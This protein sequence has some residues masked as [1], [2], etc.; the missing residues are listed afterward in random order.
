MKCHENIYE[1]YQKYPGKS[2]GTHKTCQEYPVIL[3]TTRQN[4]KDSSN[5]WTLD[6]IPSSRNNLK[7][8]RRSPPKQ[9]SSPKPQIVWAS[10]G[11]YRHWVSS[12]QSILFFL[13]HIPP[14]KSKNSIYS[15]NSIHFK[16]FPRY[17]PLAH[18]IIF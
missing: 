8:L 12:F 2:S 6:K 16:I 7:E 1:R 13:S 4:S 17:L 3:V 11:L 10:L 9:K 18:C 15:Q 14:F 5:N